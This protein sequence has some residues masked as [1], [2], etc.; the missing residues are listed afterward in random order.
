LG[1]VT[2]IGSGSDAIATHGPLRRSRIIGISTAMPIRI[3]HQIDGARWPRRRPLPATIIVMPSDDR[4]LVAVEQDGATRSGRLIARIAGAHVFRVPNSSLPDWNNG[5]RSGPPM[6]HEAGGAPAVC[7]TVRGRRGW[8]HSQPVW[9]RVEMT[10]ARTVTGLSFMTTIRRAVV[11]S[12]ARGS[13]RGGDGDS[14][15][16]VYGAIAWEP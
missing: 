9:Q 2:C 16:T 15:R 10:V 12:I 4:T 7:L 5:W 8:P 13:R 14:Q 11:R 3:C 1:C 6:G